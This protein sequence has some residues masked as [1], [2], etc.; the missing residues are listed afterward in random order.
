MWRSL[1]LSASH[2]R[3][4]YI[5][6]DDRASF[7][8]VQNSWLSRQQSSPGTRFLGDPQLLTFLPSAMDTVFHPRLHCSELMGSSRVSI[9]QRLSQGH[10]AKNWKVC[11]AGLPGRGQLLLGTLTF[12]QHKG[13]LP[14]G[15]S[16]G[17][18]TSQQAWYLC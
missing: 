4:V 7:G 17:E 18:E 8:S 13:I 11:R 3:L 5:T 15:G 16:A 10:I 2:W 1:E 9:Q 12:L 6:N 14:Q